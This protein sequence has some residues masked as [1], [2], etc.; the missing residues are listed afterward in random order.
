MHTH[1]LCSLARSLDCCLQAPAGSVSYA[2]FTYAG[3]Q[4]YYWEVNF[5]SGESSIPSASTTRSAVQT[6]DRPTFHN[7]CVQTLS[8]TPLSPWTFVGSQPMA[9][10]SPWSLFQAV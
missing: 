1:K 5:D 8:Q 10:W 4:L 7:D 9:P 6:P 2:T 3:N